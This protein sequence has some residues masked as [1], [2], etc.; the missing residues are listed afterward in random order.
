MDP[1]TGQFTEVVAV[2]GY[3]AGIA[4]D[5]AGNLYYGTDFY[6]DNKLLKFTA[7]ALRTAGDTLATATILSN[8]PGYGSGVAVDGAGHVLFTT[9]SFTAD[10]GSDGTLGIWNGTPT[11]DDN[12]RVIGTG[13]AD[14]YPTVRAVGDVTTPDGAAYLNDWDVLGLAEIHHLLS[15]DADGN[16]TVNG[17][18]LTIV[19]ANYNK[20][21]ADNAWAYGDFDGNGTVNGGDLNIVLAH[22]NQHTDVGAAVPEPSTCALLAVGAL[23][24]L[25]WRR[26]RIVD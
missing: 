21:F 9:N 19:L 5:A 10:G 8:L 22:Y 25:A 13:G 12:Y 20:T 11:E 7:D 17:G 1:T 4:T 3:A 16:G 23:A 24:A 15:G 26:R 6:S 18:D 2:G 14:W